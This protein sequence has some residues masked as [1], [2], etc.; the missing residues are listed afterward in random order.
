M[1][2]WADELENWMN[3]RDNNDGAALAAAITGVGADYGE[4]KAQRDAFLAP[5]ERFYTQVVVPGA[6]FEDAGWAGAR[7][8]RFVRDVMSRTVSRTWLA[9]FRVESGSPV[10]GPRR[11]GELR[12]QLR[13]RMGEAVEEV[14]GL[15]ERQCPA[16]EP[17]YR[18]HRMAEFAAMGANIVVTW[19]AGSATPGAVT[20]NGRDGRANEDAEMRWLGSYAAGLRGALRTNSAQAGIRIEVHVKARPCNYCGPQLNQWR[21]DENFNAVPMYAFTYHDDQNGGTTNVYRLDSAVPN[22]SKYLNKWTYR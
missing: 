6:D 21:S 13:D 15:L 8:G 12:A 14:V 5:L 11:A 3:D 9:L 20:R 17:R 1:P 10:F 18:A 16:P 2:D 7:K 4:K 19:D 22:G